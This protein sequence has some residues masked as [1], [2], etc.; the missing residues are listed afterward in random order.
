[1]RRLLV[2]AALTLTGCG[3]PKVVFENST[4]VPE[5]VNNTAETDAGR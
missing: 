3:G 2:L 1:M 5:H 4:T